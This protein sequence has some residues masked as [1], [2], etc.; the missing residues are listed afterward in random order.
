MEPDIERECNVKPCPGEDITNTPHIDNTVPVLHDALSKTGSK[1]DSD[2]YS[3]NSNHIESQGNSYFTS[4]PE[5]YEDMNYFSNTM[6]GDAPSESENQKKN[7]AI[8]SS[9]SS[10]DAK[11]GPSLLKTPTDIHKKRHKSVVHNRGRHHTGAKSE[12]ETPSEGKLPTQSETQE[13]PLR[14]HHWVASSWGP[15]SHVC[16]GGVRTRSVTCMHESTQLEVV[17]DHCTDEKPLAQETCNTHTCLA[18]TSSDWSLCS[19]SCGEGTQHREVSC[20]LPEHCDPN[21]KPEETKS[22]SATLCTKW[23]VG[24]WSQ[25]S[26]TCGGGEQLRMIQCINPSTQQPTNGCDEATQPAGAQ[27]CNS[28]PCPEAENAALSG[29]K[30]VCHRDIMSNQMCRALKRMGKCKVRYIHSRCCRTCHDKPE[31]PET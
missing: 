4:P 3:M 30:S 27:S 22:C 14:K 28:D 24:P 9:P 6:L 1:T 2:I 29:P 21:E 10:D 31:E 17:A 26:K 8:D 23:I 19:T 16:G 18:W 11:T 25:C 15:C 7:P 5:D 20:P 13:L 12:I